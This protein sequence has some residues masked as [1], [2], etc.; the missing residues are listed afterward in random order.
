VSVEYAVDGDVA[1]LTLNRPQVFNSI[2]QSLTD[3]L[4]EGLGRAATEARA[5][6]LTGVG[7]AFCAGADL[8]D[9]LG[10]YDAEGPDLESVISRRFNPAVQAV[11]D[12]ELPVVAAVN[13]V[14]AGAGMGLALACD[15]RVMSET[16]FLMSAFINVA[17]VPDTGTAWFLPQMVGVS[18]AM[19]IA[20][21]GRRVPAAEA[22]ALGL[23]AEVVEP[24]QTWSRAR[25]PG[26]RDGRRAT[27]RLRGDTPHHPP[28][29][30]PPRWP[31]ILQREA[32]VQGRLGASRPPRRHGGLRGETSP[33]LHSTDDRLGGRGGVRVGRGGPP[34]RSRRRRPCR[35]PRP[36]RCSAR[37]G[38]R[39]RCGR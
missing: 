21:S 35:W 28:G 33:G 14:A 11:L 32:A 2:D 6:V 31:D 15:V 36:P 30:E 24:D 39:C 17:L 37:R 4:A 5:A 13:G 34:V 29:G 10:E 16:A 19:E 1:V 7:K 27:H 23:V 22:L 3:Q 8:G 9:L 38:L 26:R 20:M 18:R 12:A 25:W